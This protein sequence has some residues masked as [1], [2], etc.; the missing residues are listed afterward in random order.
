MSFRKLINLNNYRP[1]VANKFKNL[2]FENIKLISTFQE[3][4]NKMNEYNDP[5]KYEH[6]V[7]NKFIPFFG[8]IEVSEYI[9]KN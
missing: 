8:W 4:N 6:I 3:Y 9:K 1:L 2:N 7:K 5:T